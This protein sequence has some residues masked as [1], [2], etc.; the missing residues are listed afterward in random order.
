[1]LT[2]ILPAFSLFTFIVKGMLSV[3][4]IKLVPSTV[5]ALPMRDQASTEPAGPGAPGAPGAPVAPGVQFAL[6]KA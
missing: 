1:M 6:N 2:S 4:P 3:V 5:L